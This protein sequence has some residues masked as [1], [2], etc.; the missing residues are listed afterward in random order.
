MCPSWLAAW[1]GVQ[2]QWLSTPVMVGA[3]GKGAGVEGLGR[4]LA[5]PYPDC[6]PPAVVKTRLQSLQRGLNE[7][8]YSG[9]L[10]C[11]RWARPQGSGLRGPQCPL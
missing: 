1:P 4:R 7:D 11:A 5:G 10:D 2:L 3:L 9:F 6:T 8:T